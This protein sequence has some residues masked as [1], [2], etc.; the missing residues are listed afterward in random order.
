M[1]EFEYVVSVQQGDSHFCKNC[2]IDLPK[3]VSSILCA[4]CEQALEEGLL[5][6]EELE[7]F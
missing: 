3:N 1:D 6:Q 5:E 7:V 4:E 2:G